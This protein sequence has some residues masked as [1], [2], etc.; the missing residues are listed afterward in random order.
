MPGDRVS[1]IGHFPVHDVVLIVPPNPAPH[2]DPDKTGDE[3]KLQRF[4]VLSDIAEELSGDVVFPICFDL[5]VRLRA[6]L[7]APKSSL[8]D[9]CK[10]VATD[11]LVCGKLLGMANS[12]GFNPGHSEVRDLKGAVQRLGLQNVRSVALGM[13]LKQLTM[14]GQMP[15]F[16]RLTKSLWDHSVRS[17]AACHVI[18]RKMT[19]LN[20]DDAFL[21]GLVH[22]IGAFY[23]FYRASKY[24]ELRRRPESLRHLVVRWHETIGEALLQAL[25]LP[26]RIS[27]A[28]REHDNSRPLPRTLR[29]LGDLVQVVNRLFGT[30]DDYLLPARTPQSELS[31]LDPYLPL[32]PDIEAGAVELLAAFA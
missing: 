1:P 23:L 19:R 8:D 32:L 26:E 30:T 2:Q 5:A 13:A 7:D 27:E 10:T 25:G 9:I 11:P 12:V 29:H 20:P 18:A 4:R 15:S 17:A 28:V 16:E 3:L 31:E 21:V 24:D 14:A 22:D 6:V